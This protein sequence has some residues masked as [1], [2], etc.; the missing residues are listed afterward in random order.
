MS[1]EN[2]GKIIALLIVAAVLLLFTFRSG[3]FFLPFD[4]F[5]GI[6]Q[7]MR[8]AWHIWP[9]RGFGFLHWFPTFIIPLAL[10]LLWVY[11]IVWVYRDAERKGMNGLLWS[12]LVLIGN[13]IGVIVYLLIR[14][15]TPARTR[16]APSEKCPDC[17]SSVIPGFIFCANCGA[18][19][20]P[21]CPGCK[22]PVNRDWRF[23]PTCGK[24]LD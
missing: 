24:S 20:K 18:R 21:E 8:N 6:A 2:N 9:F 1:P 14:S 10:L 22:K 16:E 3:F 17:G 15:E 7:A 5:A 13:I 11:V 23:C 19:L 12:L 4:I